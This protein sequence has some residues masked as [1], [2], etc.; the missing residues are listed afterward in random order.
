MRRYLKGLMMGSL[1][2]MATL[3]V[4]ASETSSVTSEAKVTTSQT[5]E[6]K[7]TETTSTSTNK[8]TIEKQST[9]A[10]KEVKKEAK[11][12]DKEWEKAKKA[13]ISF[14]QYRQI[15]EMPTLKNVSSRIQAQ[16]RGTASSGD[17]V[18]SVAEAQIGIPY[19]WGGETPEEGFDCSGLVQYSYKKAINHSLPR[20]TTDQEKQ[21]KDVSLSE[22]QKGDL[23]FYGERGNTYHVSIYAGNGQ[24]IQ[25][26]KPGENVQKINIQ[27]YYPDFARR[28][29][30]EEEAPKEVKEEAYQS[31]VSGSEKIYRNTSLT[32]TKGTTGDYYK[33]T[34][35][36]KSYFVKNG[37]RYYSAYNKNNQWI[38]YI[39]ETAL[40]KAK[41]KGGK[42]YAL[43]N[44]YGVS[45]RSSDKWSNFDFTAKKGKTTIDDQYRVKG[46]YFHF[47]GSKYYSIYNQDDQWCGYVNS[48][49]MTLANNDFGAYHS[50]GQYVTVLKGGYGIY[51]DKNF[52]KKVKMSDDVKNK[53]FFAKGYYDR[54]NGSRYYSLYS[55]DGDGLKWEGYIRSTATKVGKS[56]GGVFFSLDTTA[57]AT[58]S[59]DLWRN[60]DFTSKKGKTEIGKKYK[61]KGKYNHFRG[62]TYYSVYDLETDQWLGYVHQNGLKL[63]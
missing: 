15:M 5:T 45:T 23:L 43:N 24:S 11:T 50:Y 46:Q 57:T 31:V 42:H 38:G 2:C 10:T 21:G 17:K 41:T 37:K 8:K 33:N 7:K 61:I 25:A 3:E 56:A 16:V 19:V 35:F 29:I 48:N 36:T 59:S 27:Y 26:P 20:V 30:K 58:R 22:L 52:K 63:D 12:E 47:N 39:K 54:F 60:F 28:V 51:Q 40:E 18:V 53:T 49:G 6:T 1:L 13:G 4:Q 55:K 44:T 9:E 62:T 32:T 34:F 14:E